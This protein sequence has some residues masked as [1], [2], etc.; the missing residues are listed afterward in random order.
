[1]HA[2]MN[3]TV[4]NPDGETIAK[5]VH[6]EDAAALVAFNGTGATI[7]HDGDVLWTQGVDGD[8]GES[9]DH[10]AETMQ[11]RRKEISGR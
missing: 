9:Y 7:V 2:R 8:A 1:M 6:A 4:T 3:W 10:V 5:L 11:R